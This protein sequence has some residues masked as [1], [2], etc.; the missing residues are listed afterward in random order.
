MR[1]VIVTMVFLLATIGIVLAGGRQEGNAASVG[2]EGSPFTIRVAT[3]AVQESGT[4]PYFEALKN[5]FETDNPGI[6]I[7]WV[8][9]PYGQ[10]REQ[11]L[12]QAAA[13]NPPDVVQTARPWLPD[14]ANSGFFQPVTGLL[15]EAYIA[16]I[17]PEIRSDLLYNDE[18]Y[19]APWFYGPFVVYYNA[20]LFEQA[21]LDPDAPPT[22]YEEA[23]E[24]ARAISALSDSEEN[25]I[26]GLGMTTGSVPVSGGAV[27][28]MLMS[29]GGGV[30]DEQGNLII[31][32]AG[33]R[34]ALAFLKTL[35]AERLNPEGALLKDLRNLF[36]IG[37]LGIYI[38]QT[39]GMNGVMAINPDA[40]DYAR[41]ALPFGTENSPP[42]STL[43]GHLL[44]I[45]ADAE[46]PEAAATFIEYVTSREQLAAYME[47]LPFLLAR[48]SLGDM[49]ELQESIVAPIAAG[50]PGVITA[51]P[52]HPK[53]T[54]LFL[55][56]TK[57]AQMVTIGGS[58]PAE[59]TAAARAWADREL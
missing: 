7:E 33:N 4:V 6:E 43:E 55:E 47:S 24:A 18:L 26:Y 3:W 51:V 1:R 42:R 45:P 5:D 31:D 46:H 11:V 2:G 37:R 19:A 14:F 36:A 13:G 54:D 16:D 49:P 12:I 32:G 27:L 41:I 9:F 23:L 56:L 38:D 22:T 50:A 29:F 15:S 30:W 20:D 58:D 35:H 40:A 44:T 48:S 39:W 57:I 8:G 25:R 52:K 21:G 10:L 17:Y 53:M 34:E 28:T 59:A